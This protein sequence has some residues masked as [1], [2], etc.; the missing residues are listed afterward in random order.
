MPGSHS[1][2]RPSRLPLL[3]V[4][5]VV[6]FPHMSLPLSVGRERS[7]KALEAAAQGKRVFVVAQR[8]AAI[9]EPS[10]KDFFVVGV[11][12]DVVQSIRMPDGTLKVFLQGL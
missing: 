3:A 4:R 5:D 6:V 8:Q 10:A 9:E 12:A 2:E 7:I 11:V 1:A